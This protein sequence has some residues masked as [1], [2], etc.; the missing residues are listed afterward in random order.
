MN[1]KCPDCHLFLDDED[2]IKEGVYKCPKCQTI[3]DELMLDIE[4]HP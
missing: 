4:S 3:F 2:K 1:Y